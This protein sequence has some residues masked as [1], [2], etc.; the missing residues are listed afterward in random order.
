MLQCQCGREAPHPAQASSPHEEPRDSGAVAG[1]ASS[2][3]GSSC[4]DERALGGRRSLED[5]GLSMTGLLVAGDVRPQGAASLASSSCCWCGSWGGGA[6]AAAVAG[7]VGITSSRSPPLPPS[8]ASPPPVC[9]PASRAVG[10]LA[11]RETDEQLRGSSWVHM[12]RS[13]ATRRK[14]PE[15]MLACGAGRGMGVEGTASS[16]CTAIASD[17]RHDR[18]PRGGD[19]VGPH[20]VTELLGT[21]SSQARGS[22]LA[23]MRSTT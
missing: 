10:W 1:A 4:H 18:G 21:R 8:A 6:L 9:C 22:G 13:A 15:N 12:A 5:A 23:L 11:G 3:G 19:G 14:L 17:I 2:A 7:D 20:A 16:S